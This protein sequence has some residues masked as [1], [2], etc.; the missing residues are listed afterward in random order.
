MKKK[1]NSTQMIKTRLENI[2]HSGV[3]LYLD[4]RRVSP[5]EIADIYAVREDVAYMPDYVTDDRGVLKEVRYD[6]IRTN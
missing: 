3:N 2:V 6:K 1:D 5:Q 4:G